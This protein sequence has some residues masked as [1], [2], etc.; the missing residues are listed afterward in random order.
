VQKQFVGS[1]DDQVWME[2]SLDG[3]LIQLVWVEEM[4]LTCR[5]NHQVL[6]E[7]SQGGNLDLQIWM[8]QQLV[9][10]LEQQ[11]WMED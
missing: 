1:L 3:S 2:D 6:V 8:E 9:C 5:L 4:Q 11:V 10:S 7:D